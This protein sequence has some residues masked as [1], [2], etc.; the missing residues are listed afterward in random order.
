M[1]SKI[2]HRLQQLYDLFSGR[3][4]AHSDLGLILDDIDNSIVRVILPYQDKHSG[5][6]QEGCL[7]STSILTAI[8]STCGFA[9][10]L[11]L[12]T[13]QAIATVNLRVD[14]ICRPG[15]GQ[16]VALEADCYAQEGGFAYVKAKAV[17]VDKIDLYS[18]C[19]GV[20]KIG[21]PGPDLLPTN[22]SKL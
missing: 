7:H 13:P 5:F 4:G 22:I 17:S 21:S 18:S 11:S 20:F 12:D 10:M 8:D 16:D 19:I 6:S 3:V 14:H 9:V 2:P 1:T 15:A